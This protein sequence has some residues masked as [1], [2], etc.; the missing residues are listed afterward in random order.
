MVRQAAAVTG[1]TRALL[2][3]LNSRTGELRSEAHVDFSDELTRQALAPGSGSFGH[4][5]RTRAPVLSQRTEAEG[6]DLGT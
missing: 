4:V 5:A 3:R 2:S 6:F 1:G